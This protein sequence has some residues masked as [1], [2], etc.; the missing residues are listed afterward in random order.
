MA[1][2]S[3]HKLMLEQ[4]HEN[5]YMRTPK[6]RDTFFV[7]AHKLFIFHSILVER[8]SEIEITTTEAQLEIFWKF[9]DLSC[10]KRVQGMLS[11]CDTERS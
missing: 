6:C 5:N 2:N 1:R 9:V 8:A 4:L 10:A 11:V 3:F 7:R